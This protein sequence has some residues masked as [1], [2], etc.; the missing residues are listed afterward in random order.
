[1]KTL[2]LT[3]LLSTLLLFPAVGQNL[4][5][6]E[7]SV[8]RIF[9]MEDGSGGSGFVV[10]HIGHIGTNH[11]VVGKAD[12]LTVVYHAGEVVKVKTASVIA[13]SEGL[14][15]AIIKVSDLNLP[16]LTL[17]SVL[18]TKGDDV[19]ALGYPGQ[20]DN[21][22]AVAALV[23]KCKEDPDTSLTLT[24]ELK[25]AMS[26]PVKRGIYEDVKNFSWLEGGGILENLSREQLEDPDFMIRLRANPQFH[27][28]LEIIQHTAPINHGNSGGPLFDRDYRVIGVNTAGNID[29]DKRVLCLSS[30]ISEFI[31]FATDNGV[32]LQTTAAV[33][34]QTSNG[35]DGFQRTL[36]ILLAVLVPI[37]FLLV[38]RKPRT[39]MVD[40]MSRMVGSRRAG[41][42]PPR[43][44]GRPSP[45][46]QAGR[47][48]SPIPQTG[49]LR[50]RGRDSQGR[51]F[52][53]PFSA[54]DFQRNGGR[55]IIGRKNDLCQLVL[56]HD[57][58]S[59]QHAVLTMQG[60]TVMVEDRNSGNGT[61]INGRELAVGAAAIPL[62]AGDRLTLGEV[63]LVFEV[64]L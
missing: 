56:S 17:A 53:L 19:I 44:P 36:L 24:A 1:M 46:D 58:I 31:K 51:S 25:Q 54:G 3:F 11:H 41:G 23:E 52:D 21:P 55:L 48:N 61:K 12:T 14:D 37:L 34:S 50:L 10:S 40:A 26:I 15:L 8:V 39:V 18:P 7:K 63:E 35:D 6:A 30:N 38:L 27:T 47:M 9:N 5:E 33:V 62:Q 29:E 28:K 4:Q 59:R 20:S 32:P 57:S 49:T 16:P 22:L 2:R 60:G 43:Q 45:D 64:F 13:K 42:S